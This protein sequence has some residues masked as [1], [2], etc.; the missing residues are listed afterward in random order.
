MDKSFD[1]MVHEFKEKLIESI[2]ESQLPLSCVRYVLQ[3]TTQFI[4]GLVER[5]I[6]EEKKDIESR[7]E[8]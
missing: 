6:S 2:N 7:K 8:E 4:G 3:E 1:L 5:N